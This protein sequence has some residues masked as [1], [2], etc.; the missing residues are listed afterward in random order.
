M[1]CFG[2]YLQQIYLH[3]FCAGCVFGRIFRGIVR[4]F[5]HLSDHFLLFK[6]N[7][8]RTGCIFYGGRRR[9]NVPFAFGGEFWLFTFGFVCR[10][11]FGLLSVPFHFWI[12]HPPACSFFA[13]NVFSFYGKNDNLGKKGVFVLGKKVEENVEIAC[14]WKKAKKIKRLRETS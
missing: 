10:G 7:G 13:E 14:F 2:G 4:P 12:H 8:S 3:G 6:G 9:G 1:R 11:N 5:S